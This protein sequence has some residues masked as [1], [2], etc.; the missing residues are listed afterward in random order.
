MQVVKYVKEGKTQTQI[1]AMLGT[2][3][4]PMHKSV[5]SMLHQCYDVV[6]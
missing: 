4:H 1:A 3:E 2:K 6:K 5:V